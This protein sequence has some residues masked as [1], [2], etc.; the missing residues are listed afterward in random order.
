E[1]S[2][3]LIKQRDKFASEKDILTKVKSVVSKR[4]LEQIAKV[5][6]QDETAENKSTKASLKKKVKPATKN[7][8]SSGTVNKAL[9]GAPE[10]RFYTKVKPMLATLVDE[11]VDTD[12]WLYEIKWDGY[13]AVS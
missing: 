13:R 7:K 10:Q 6:G 5:E 2:W 3:L 8:E 1:N 4:S 11:P 9:K 12:E